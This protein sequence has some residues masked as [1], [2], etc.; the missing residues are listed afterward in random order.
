MYQSP[1]QPTAR[2]SLVASP[3]TSSGCGPSFH[4]PLTHLSYSST[5][6]YFI[7]AHRE[8]CTAHRWLA[9]VDGTMVVCTLGGLC[10]LFALYCM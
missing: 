2:R 6:T 10:V 8:K 9:A 3:T 5:T 4:R 7:I 1:G